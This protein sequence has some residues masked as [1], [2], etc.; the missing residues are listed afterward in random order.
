MRFYKLPALFLVLA[1]MLSLA[2]Y[3][4]AYAASPSVF[5]N[6]IHYDNTGTDTG[7]AV[8]IAGPAG[9]DL[10]GW[11]LVL[12][13]GSNGSVYDT[14][15]LSGTIPD[16]GGGFGVVVVNY[17]SNGLQN[18]S[19]D[20]IALVDA[21]NA[22]VQ[23]L[24]YEGTFN[25]VGGP[26]DGMTSSDIGVAESS[27]TAVGD[28]LQLAGTGVTYD[29]FS[30]VG[31]QA[32]TFGAFNTGQEFVSSAVAV[33]VINEIDY[34]QPGTDTTEFIEIKN[35]GTESADL[36]EYS[37]ELVNGTGGGASIYTSITFGNQSLAAGDY[38]V[39][40][41]DYFAVNNCDVGTTP[42]NMIQNGSPDAVGLRH[43]GV[44][45]DTVS[46]EG[47][48]GAPYTEGSGT[49][50]EDDPAIENAGI[51][52]FPDGTDTDQN[53]VDFSLRCS[54][55]G[56][57]NVADSS[58]CV[59]PNTN[60]VINEID[61]DQPG[62]DTAEFVEILNRGT[63]PTNL[64]G[65]SLEL[66]N[67][68]GGG[69]AMYGN[70][71]LSGYTLAAGDYFVVCGD[72]AN[73]QNCDLDVSPD[74][75]LIQNGSPD[76][77]GLRFNG[78]LIDT[79]SYEG[80]TGAPYTEGSGTGLEDSGDGSISRC[81]DGVD[82][83]QNNLNFNF[84]GITPGT[85]NDCEIPLPDAVVNEFSASTTGTDVEYVEI[86]GAPS[87]DF[88]SLTILEIEGD[89]GSNMGVVD[90]VIGLGSTDANG[91]FLANLSANTL[92]NGTISLLL[93]QN[94]SGALGDDLDPNDDGAL[95]VT[96]WDAVVDAV[97]VDD[98]DPG[99]LTYG[100]PALGPNYDG[101]SSFAPGGA[102]RIPDGADTDTAADW[103]R[104]DFD[105]AGIPGYTG[106]LGP[107]E[108]YN[109]PGAINEVFVPPAEM[110]GDPFTPIYTIQGSG[111]ASP[112]DGTE[113]STEG[114]VVGDFQD[115][116]SGFHIQD[117]TGDGDATTSDGIF[118][119][120]TGLDVNVGDYVRVRGFVDEFF[121]LT[122]ITGVSQVW[123]C[124]SGSVAPTA[125]AL[126]VTSV[127]DFEAYEGML[128]TLPQTLYISEF[129]NFDRFGEMV[130]TTER[131]FQPTAV[132]EPGSTDAADLALAN[133]LSRITL[134][135][136]RGSQNPDPAIHPNG[137]VFDLTNLFR[138]G[139]ELRNVT[140]VLD[141][142]FGLYKIQPTQ[143]ADYTPVNPRTAL[144]DDVGG[145]LKV[146]AFN[147]LNYF[148][149]LDDGVNDICGP[150]ENQECRGA[151]DAEEFT[152]Q[153]DKIIAALAA[154]D[155]DV[156]GLIEIENHPGDVPTEDLVN[157]L[158]DTMGAGTYDYIAT[159]AV[160]PDAIRVA[161]IY[162]PATVTPVGAHAVLDTPAFLDPNNLGDDKNR[163]ALAQTFMDNTTGG[164]F[165]P[166]VNHLKSKGSPCGP[167]DDDPE[168]GSCN[169]TR[170]LAAQE[171]L[172]WLATDPTGSGDED[173]LI[174]GDLNSYDKED[175]IDVLLAAGYTDLLSQFHGEFAYSYVFNGQ[176]G[177]LDYALASPGMMD[178]VTGVTAWHINADEADLIDYDTSFKK[179]AQ[180]AIYAPDAYRSSDHDPVIVGLD[181][182]DEIA[183]VFEEV[184]VTPDVLWP[185]NHQYVDVTATV[186]VSDNF[187]P[188]PMVE[189]VSVE[190]NEPDDG[191]G[192]GD[193]ADD[194]VIVDTYHVML[195]AE[196]SG[197]GE[198]RIY[199]I[200]YKVTD[201]C[202]NSAMYS[203][204]VTVPKSQGKNK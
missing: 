85:A 9:T 155:A 172:D 50:L 149:T 158:N 44:L 199:T 136:G 204:T 165:T 30:W 141:Y 70:I 100:L 99:D 49:G 114:V 87:T 68:T 80:E 185:P 121:D 181:V 159:G 150:L 195:R 14:D 128:V 134:D 94:F 203:V 157:G 25:A 200:T 10:T 127:D 126:P 117:A 139:D 36:S 91:F 171:L 97:A 145:D 123:L 79:V 112:L 84:T 98:G 27:S 182:C 160:G 82:T 24:S 137:G 7:E 73:V 161:F 116:L 59:L 32:N 122:E 46:Y 201:A 33:L 173:F 132:Y 1:M 156:V 175:P 129:F 193:T 56:E 143:G 179:D 119:Y 202:G 187:D 63:D 41:G 55:P 138:G 11:S 144:P 196:R 66:V 106:S 57:A 113:V 191:L 115:G 96:P 15:S 130:L 178:E 169:L 108:A 12:Y 13:N 110:C 65:W 17:P 92:E 6:E 31:E 162:K 47:D 4:P 18:G 53:N 189:L 74:S 77:V 60:L 183:P 147:V 75:N 105:L 118:V 28:S 164:V 170:T 26:A 5:I 43:N 192:D 153:R 22:V 76:A 146:A 197:T 190:S 148:T 64:T 58:D 38:F 52:R 81:N 95:D 152:R 177:Y 176:L 188:N 16:L 29:D 23:F 40:C 45:V 51:S 67:G 103:V 142:N 101:V 48:S 71:D 135:D 3:T 184:S 35:V 34:D 39:V 151:D 166:V 78:N 154:M 174:I 163:A 54:T 88:S 194:I 21:S 86:F 89:S 120:Y 186:V 109:T 198:G 72:A 69:A 168:A 2:P 20:G 107:G 102:S 83:D 167:G 19:P 93:V 124:G 133:S 125:I 61:Y 90:E 62:T 37:L 42:T 140:G 180:D 8:E 111:L 131:Q 104:N